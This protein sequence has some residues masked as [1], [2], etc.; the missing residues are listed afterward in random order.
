[1]V[2]FSS[3]RAMNEHRLTRKQEAFVRQHV[4]LG[5]VNASAA[6]V[7]AGY[8]TGAGVTAHRLL[9]KPHVLQ[10]IRLEAER[11]LNAGLP[12]GTT[13]L[14]ELA[15]NANNEAVR[16][17]AATELIDRG[18]LRLMNLSQHTVVIKDERSDDELRA[19]IMRLQRELGLDARVIDAAVEPKPLPAPSDTAVEEP[20]D[21]A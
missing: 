14:Q 16:L 20:S 21:A 17:K 4:R 8:G 11:S 12:I 2:V 5:G 6:A 7:A 3:E 15:Q 19:Q 10:A 13:V 1:L 9:R 18:G